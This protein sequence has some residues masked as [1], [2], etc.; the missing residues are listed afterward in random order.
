MN[1]CFIY[2]RRGIHAF[3]AHCRRWNERKKFR[4]AKFGEKLGAVYMKVFFY[5]FSFRFLAF[6]L[7][8][9]CFLLLPS[10]TFFSLYHTVSYPRA[11]DEDKSIST[12][13][14]FNSGSARCYSDIPNVRALA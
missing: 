14:S 8:I 11:W 13:N 1:C 3:R 9:S 12:S 2:S 5:F 7:V 4:L 6:S 10:S